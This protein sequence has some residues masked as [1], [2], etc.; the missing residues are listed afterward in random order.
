MQEGTR[1]NELAEAMAKAQ[2][3]MTNPPKTRT[4]NAGKYSYAYAELDSIID[5]VRPVLA[6]NGLAVIQRINTTAEAVTLITDLVHESGQLIDST[7]PL[8]KGCAAQEFGSYLT[9]ARRY[10]LC[11]ILGIA[12]ESD[13]DA[14]GAGG[15]TA[16]AGSPELEKAR[17]EIIERICEDSVSNVMLIK[18]CEI[19]GLDVGKAKTSDDMSLEVLKVLLDRWGEVVALA[20]PPK[21]EQK[22]VASKPVKEKVDDTEAAEDL[23]MIPPKLRKLMQRDGVSKAALKHVYVSKGHLPDDVEPDDL[24]ED[25]VD[26]ICD[27]AVWSK[28]RDVAMQYK[29]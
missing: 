23:T 27:S 1:I 16:Q 5:H 10:S 17:D 3:E 15:V 9:Y 6:K 26:Q 18:W 19:E 8:P 11:A 7:H 4:V 22:P 29:G 13:D 24:P 21:K 14:Q 2:G 25:Y 20:H 28:V 12:A